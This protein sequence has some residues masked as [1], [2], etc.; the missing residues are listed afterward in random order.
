[1]TTQTMEQIVQ[2]DPSETTQIAALDEKIGAL[3]ERGEQSGRLVISDT[4]SIEIP[5]SAMKALRFVVE[6]MA[7][8]R[9][10]TLVP[11]GK[12]LTTGQTADILNVSRP[13]LVRMLEAGKIPFHRVGTHRRLKIDDVLAYR[14]RR[15]QERRRA[16]EDLV[17][18]SERLPGG[19]R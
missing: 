16:L 1:M 5:A 13:H 2:P 15:A 8:G 18:L 3:F 10:I 7:Q 11:R 12:E 19:Y 6:G 14:E 9:T 4:E 17:T